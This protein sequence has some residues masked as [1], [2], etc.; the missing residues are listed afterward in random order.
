MFLR[1]L[2]IGCIFIPRDREDA[3]G[4]APATATEIERIIFIDGELTSVRH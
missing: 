4:K 1:P 2:M 3:R